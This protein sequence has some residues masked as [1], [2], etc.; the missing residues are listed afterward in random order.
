MMSKRFFDVDCFVGL[1][2]VAL[3]EF[4]CSLL[5]LFYPHL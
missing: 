5:L 1:I 2:G 4:F 3:R